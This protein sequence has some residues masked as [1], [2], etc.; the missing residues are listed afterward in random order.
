MRWL[1]WFGFWW[2]WPERAHQELNRIPVAGWVFL[3]VLSWG[4][5]FLIGGTVVMP[6]LLEG[7]LYRV[8]A[9]ALPGCWQQYGEADIAIF[10]SPT[11]NNSANA[12][13]LYQSRHDEDREFLQRRGITS[14]STRLIEMTPDQKYDPW[15]MTL[16]D[17]DPVVIERLDSGQ[18]DVTGNE[19]FPSGIWEACDP[20]VDRSWRV[21]RR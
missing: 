4:G 7:N 19:L 1:Y 5:F 16:D 12:L 18:I 21:R 10:Y 14:Y 6:A 9:R 17:S 11:R 8:A 15:T 3:I 13:Y 2:L 20:P